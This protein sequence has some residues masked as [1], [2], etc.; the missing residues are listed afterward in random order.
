MIQEDF[1][2]SD[3]KW[4][5]NAKANS[6]IVRHKGKVLPHDKALKDVSI[7]FNDPLTI[8]QEEE[9][10]FTFKVEVRMSHHILC[11]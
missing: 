5:D 8:E 10:S 6:M 4:S 1:R 3:F 2:T 9:C 7:T 11:Q